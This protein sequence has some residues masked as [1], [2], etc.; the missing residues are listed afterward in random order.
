MQQSGG[1][2]LAPGWTGATHLSA[3]GADA[4]ESPRV[5][6]K[7]NHSGRS[8]FSFWY[9]IHKRRFEHLNATVRGTVACT[10]LD[11]RNTFICARR[12]CKRISSGPPKRR[13]PF[14]VVF[15]LVWYSREEIRTSKCNSPGGSDGSAASGGISDLSEW[16]RS[17]DDKERCRRSQM[18]GTATGICLRP[19]GRAQHNYLRKAQMQT[20]LLGSTKNRHSS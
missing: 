18:P 4:N 14:G 10:R 2:L 6:Q 13:P 7:G 11:G 1:L 5:H 16:Q 8:G 12:R 9:G 15:F 3:Q 19:A 20:N 17:A